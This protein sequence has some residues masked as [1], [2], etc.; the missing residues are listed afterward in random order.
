M[1]E[2]RSVAITIVVYTVL[3]TLSIW[4]MNL[5]KWGLTGLIVALG[6]FSL[7]M[8]LPAKRNK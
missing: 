3:T 1:I 2:R 4:T 7:I 5:T 6:I 8:I